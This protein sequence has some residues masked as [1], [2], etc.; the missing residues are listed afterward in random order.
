M[1]A[2]VVMESA[3]RQLRHIPGIKAVVLGGSRACG[4]E[5]SESDIDIGLYYQSGY[6]IDTEA[7]ESLASALDDEHRNGLITPIGGWGPWIN[8]GGWLKMGGYSMDLLYRDAEIVTGVIT[9]CRKGRIDIHYQP[10]H[11]HGFCTSIYMGEA[12]YCR[13]LWDPDGLVAEMKTLTDPYPD[14][15][16]Q[17]TIAKFMW[18]AD[19]SVSNAKK[20]W[21]R[22]DVSYA[23]GHL[24]RT[25]SCLTQVL[26]ACNGVYL[27]NE[28]GAVAQCSR[29]QLAPSDFESRVRE[30]FAC[31][32]AERSDLYKAIGIFEAL[33]RETAEIAL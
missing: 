19:F 8:G 9:D 23:A 13:P 3:V 21:S 15:L 14:P 32:T 4:T 29:F 26:F 10:G 20:A 7:L 2:N 6:P 25:V 5:T 18:E 22:K 1:D 24:F 27:L 17:A 12:A 33:V 31:L 11:P 30:G 16:R 28:K